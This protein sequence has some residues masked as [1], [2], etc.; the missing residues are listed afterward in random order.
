MN[1]CAGGILRKENKI[2]LGKR[3]A[4]RSFYPHV[5]DIIGGHGESNE[6]PEHT[7]VRELK[8]ELDVIATEWKLLAVLPD[9]EPGLNEQYIYHVYLVT[10][11][12]GSPRNILIDEHDAL[13]WFEIYEVLQLDL[14]LSGYT[15]VFRR[16]AEEIPVR[17]NEREG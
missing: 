10:G 1:I 4:H 6:T 9:Q 15:E 5:W 17:Y 14:A 12:I 2:L 7:L 3:S 16:L 13:G 11:W 8:E